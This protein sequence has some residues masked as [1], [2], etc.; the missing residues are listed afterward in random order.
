[1]F[2]RPTI[3]NLSLER[4]KI[5]SLGEITFL[6]EGSEKKELVNRILLNE[7]FSGNF[8]TDEGLPKEEIESYKKDS[9]ENLNMNIITYHD[10][11]VV[12]TS[13]ETFNAYL[14][15]H[16]Q[17]YIFDIQTMRKVWL[18]QVFSNEYKDLLRDMANSIA[19][20]KL[21][22]AII[23]KKINQ[24]NPDRE[25]PFDWYKKQEQIYRDCNVVYERDLQDFSITNEGIKFQIGNCATRVERYYDDL[26]YQY[27]TIKYSEILNYLSEYG[28]YLFKTIATSELNQKCTLDFNYFSSEGFELTQNTPLEYEA[29]FYGEMGQLKQIIFLSEEFNIKEVIEEETEYD[30]PFYIEDFN[31]ID[32]SKNDYSGSDLDQISNINEL[33]EIFEKNKKCI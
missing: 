23:E 6:I 20:K 5:S 4:R 15:N 16:S 29:I 27:G 2:K 33:R 17:E 21:D 9:V 22:L 10:F 32:V 24:A 26:Y 13:Y 18:E 1:M 30:K 14:E 11:L 8:L 25:L 7:F 3:N 31:V 28:K 12:N 19:Q